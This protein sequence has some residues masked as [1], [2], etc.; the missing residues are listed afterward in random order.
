MLSLWCEKLHQRSFLAL[1]DKMLL[2]PENWTS[3]Q[4]CFQRKALIKRRKDKKRNKQKPQLK[5]TWKIRKGSSTTYDSSKAQQK[6]EKLLT[7]QEFMQW[8]ETVT[9]QATKSNSTSNS[10]FLQ[11]TLFT[12]ALQFPFLFFKRVPSLLWKDVHVVCHGCRPQTAI[13]CWFWINS[14][15]KKK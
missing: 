8:E 13:L 11:W 2:K 7:W 12:T 6:K 10:Q 14:F 5:Q 15:L 9:S 4:Q 1:R 3:Y